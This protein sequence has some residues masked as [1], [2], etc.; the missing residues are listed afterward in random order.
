MTDVSIPELPEQ[1]LA[2]V[3]DDDLIVIY[4]QGSNVAKFVSRVNFFKEIVREGGDHNFGV[5]EIDTLTATSGTVNVLNIVTSIKFSI[6][7]TIQSVRIKNQ[8][9][10]VPTLAA[11]AKSTQTTTLS[12]VTSVDFISTSFVEDLPD[13][14]VV[15]SRISADDT[16]ELKFYNSTSGSI[17][18]ATYSSKSIVTKA[19]QS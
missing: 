7:A 17:T 14:L 2:D 12:G 13:G 5:V 18:G 15:V 10:I 16:L 9:F 11:G 19:S 8:S 3:S 4:D 6:A 1:P